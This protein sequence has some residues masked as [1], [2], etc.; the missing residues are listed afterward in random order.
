[1]V[2]IKRLSEYIANLH[3]IF[4]IIPNLH[5]LTQNLLIHNYIIDA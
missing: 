4:K 3:Y 5:T 2:Y 1:M